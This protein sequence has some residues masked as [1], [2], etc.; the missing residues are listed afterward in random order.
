MGKFFRGALF[1]EREDYLDTYNEELNYQCSRIILPAS[2]ICIFGWLN[3]I[4]VDR[5]LFPSE[6][7]M[8]YLRY[9]LTIIGLLI[10]RSAA[11]SRN[12]SRRAGQLNTKAS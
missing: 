2:F 8:A 5:Q 7:M 10:P 12:T 3:Y 11:Q 1:Q 9:G 4:S 6:F